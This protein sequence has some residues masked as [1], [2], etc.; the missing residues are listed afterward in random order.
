MME[1]AVKAYKKKYIEDRKVDG[2]EKAK[3]PNIN[4]NIHRFGDT[5]SRL[6]D[7]DVKKGWVDDMGLLPLF[8]LV[9]RSMPRELAYW[10]LSRVDPSRKTFR[11]PGDLVFPIT[12]VHVH[13]VLGIP[14]NKTK[15][16]LKELKRKKDRE[17]EDFVEKYT[18][19]RGENTKG[20]Y[21]HT[22]EEVL[23]DASVSKSEFQKA[24]LMYS[25]CMVLCPTTC[26]KVRSSLMPL[27]SLAA[28]AKS[29]DWSEFVYENLCDEAKK[30][31]RKLNEKSIVKGIGGCIYVLVVSSFFTAKNQ[32][33]IYII[34]VLCY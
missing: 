21:S 29:Y 6:L 5:V 10:I 18:S 9:N 19:T 25:L 28:S 27:V 31:D 8:F 32:Y 16:K 30:F 17:V 14:V 26:D 20:V 1:G 4:C 22:L 7:S 11:G 33:I 15:I 13:W 24:F 23:L 12:K 2:V 34:F 3:S